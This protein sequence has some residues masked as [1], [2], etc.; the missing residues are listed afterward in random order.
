M[1]HLLLTPRD[2]IQDTFKLAD[3]AKQLGWKVERSTNYRPSPS[4]DT[5]DIVLYGETLFT[6]LAAKSLGYAILEPDFDLLARIPETYLRRRAQRI[7]LAE[8][9]H[10]NEPFFGKPADGN[11]AFDARVYQ[12]GSEIPA[13]YLPRSM[14]V[15]ISM[16]VI[17]AVE[18]RFFI[19]ERQIATYSIYARFGN[20][21]QD[22]GSSAEQDQAILFCQSLL[23]DL[24]IALPPA[25]VMDIGIIEQQ[26]WALVEPN[27]VSSSGIYGCDPAHVL[28]TLK[29]ACIRQSE[30]SE[31]DKRWCVNRPM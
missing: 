26:G 14:P 11:K 19:L 6:T 22:K 31:T 17:W 27:P 21:A 16:P 15:L 7:T 5:D 28:S 13:Q 25:V 8:A 9:L 10:L 30:L 29:R 1:P 4:D 20:L 2:D 18:Y 24:T 23:H 12:H 3:A